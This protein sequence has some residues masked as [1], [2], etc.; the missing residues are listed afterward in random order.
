MTTPNMPAVLTVPE[1]AKLLR[2]SKPTAYSIVARGL[3]PGVIK[4]GKVIRLHTPTV[5]AWMAQ[6]SATLHGSDPCQ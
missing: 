1:L 3:V 2:V 4:L 5:V 6:G